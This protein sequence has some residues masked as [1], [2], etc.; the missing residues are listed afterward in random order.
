MCFYGFTSKDLDENGKVPMDEIV[1][2]TRDMSL[3]LNALYKNGSKYLLPFIEE[4]R[5][6][7][8]HTR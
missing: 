7:Q 3:N 8:G 5:K 6:N 1:F 2:D 4:I